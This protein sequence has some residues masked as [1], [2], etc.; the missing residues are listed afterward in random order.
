MEEVQC[1]TC[2]FTPTGEYHLKMHDRCDH[3]CGAFLGRLIHVNAEQ[4]C[5]P[6]E[7]NSDA[8]VSC[9][10]AMDLL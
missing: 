1:N 3:G 5:V 6:E 8:A 2:I 7:I 4:A 9:R 10:Q